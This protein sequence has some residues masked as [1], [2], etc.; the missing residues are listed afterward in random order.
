MSSTEHAEGRAEARTLPPVHESWLPREHS[1]YRPRHG[2]QRLALASMIVFFFAPLVALPVFGSPQTTENRRLA[3]FPSP[4][5]GWQFLPNL[6]AW[7]N[8][9][10]SFKADAIAVSDWVSREIFGERPRLGRDTQ[11]PVGPVAPPPTSQPPAPQRQERDTEVVAN[12]YQSVIEGRDDWLYLGYD[13]QGKCEPSQPLADVVANIARL[14]DA[15]EQSGRRFVLVIA[16]DKTTI[17]PFYLPKQYAGKDCAAKASDKFWRAMSAERGVVDLRGLLRQESERVNHPLYFEQDTHWTFEGGLL[18]TRALT[19]VLNPG[20][21]GS[22]KVLPGRDWQ[23]PADLPN[24]IG[25][26]G[27]NR[28]PMLGLAPDG[29]DGDR[30]N[31][32]SGDFRTTLTFQRTAGPGMIPAKTAMLAD[33]YTRFATGYLSAVF[34]DITITHVEQLTKDTQAVADRLIPADTVVIEVVERHLAAG[35]SPVTNPGF[36]DRMAATVAAHPRR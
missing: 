33:S 35:V 12:G 4:L 9:H 27:Q 7:A 18:M 24:L 15:V 26:T 16:P 23:G 29:G 5:D 17:E 36:V 31:W 21:A 1:L 25:A 32:I 22:W 11:Q 14:R 34:A 3:D 28:A 13:V 19:N 10:L 6:S 20:A 2:T 8:D 30:T